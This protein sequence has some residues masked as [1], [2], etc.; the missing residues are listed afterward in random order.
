MLQGVG[1][2]LLHHPV[3]RQARRAGHLERLAHTPDRDVE[4]GAPDA[5]D[6]RGE[7]TEARLGGQRG[8]AV[9]VSG[10]VAPAAV[11]PATAIDAGA[12]RAGHRLVPQDA[13]HAPHVGQ[14]LAPRARDLV[15]GLG[16]PSRVSVLR[17]RGGV[18]QRHHHLNVVRDH[19]VHLPGDA[20][21]L[22]HRRQR[23]LLVAVELQPC[24]PLGQP[25]ELAAQGAHHHPG[26]QRREDEAGQEDEA[27]RPVARRVPVHR[28]HHD[29]RFQNGRGGGHETPLG[30]ERHRVEGDEECDVGQSRI[31]DQP[32]NERNPRD[33]EEHGHRRPAPEHQRED[34]GCDEQETRPGRRGLDEPARAHHE[35]PGGQDQVDQRGVAAVEGAQPLPDAPRAV[36]LLPAAVSGS[37]TTRALRGRS[38]SGYR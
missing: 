15:N 24:G 3:D 11:S 36:V 19:V 37:V 33:D 18:G 21:P 4:P 35:Q 30:L 23:G 32:L 22:R 28:G 12:V 26:Q 7:L 9:A 14:R 2:S 1:Q 34:Q 25:V 8:V 16:S 31:G 38:H 27:L 29:A 6:E 10:D 17:Q 5:L 20:G 13:Q